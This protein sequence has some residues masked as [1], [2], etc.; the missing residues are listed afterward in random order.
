MGGDNLLGL[1]R[2][3]EWCYTEPGTT[4]AN[5]MNFVMNHVSGAGSI[6]RPVDQHY[7]ALLLYHRCPRANEMKF[8][9]NHA[10]GTGSIT[11]LLACNTIQNV[12]FKMLLE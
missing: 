2:M 12:V 11:W 6:A 8:D 5:E 9:V 1:M 4:W 3:N 7:S 10:P